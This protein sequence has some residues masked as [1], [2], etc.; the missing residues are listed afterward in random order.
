MLQRLLRE[1]VGAGVTAVEPHVFHPFPPEI[2]SHWFR[3][4]RH[5]A[6]RD[7]VPTNTVAVHWY[8]SVRTKA[9]I[10]AVTPATIIENRDRQFYSALV[11]A[12]IG[13]FLGRVAGSGN[14]KVTGSLAILFCMGFLIHGAKAAGATA[15]NCDLASAQTTP[16]LRVTA[17]GARSD[18][19]NITFTLY[20][21]DAAKFLKSHGSIALTRVPLRN[22]SAEACFAVP[23]P[24]SFAVAIYH[25]EN[26]NHHFD[27]NFLDFLPRI[28]GSRRI[29]LC[30]L[31][32]LRSG[33]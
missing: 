29:R 5:V 4:R 32:R 24:G 14:G 26:D 31:D 1:P 3:T 6:L 27:R 10:S 18:L 16:V 17:T 9:A 15:I 8:A 12:N 20:G 23:A 2:S 11:H 19:G 25:D 33:R 13:R 7:I 22:H 21:D 30:C 28:M